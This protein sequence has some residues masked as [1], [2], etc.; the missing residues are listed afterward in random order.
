LLID[1]ELSTVADNLIGNAGPGL[2]GEIVLRDLPYDPR[3]LQ[4]LSGRYFQI[5]QIEEGGFLDVEVIS[6]SLYDVTINLLPQQQA[7]FTAPSPPLDAIYLDVPGPDGEQLRVIARVAEIPNLEGRYLFL[8]G[9]ASR[10]ILAP[11][12]NIVGVAFA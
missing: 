5:A 10:A 7:I 3:Y 2:A 12:A 11:A 4:G 6:P 8:V 1:P 9:I